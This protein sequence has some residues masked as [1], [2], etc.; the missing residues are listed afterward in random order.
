MARPIRRGAAIAG[1]VSVLV[2]TAL[3]GFWEFTRPGATLAYQIAGLVLL[4]ILLAAALLLARFVRKHGDEIG[5]ARFDT[6]SKDKQ[7]P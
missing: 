2:M 7:L 4:A 1:G 3:A 5:E 6:S